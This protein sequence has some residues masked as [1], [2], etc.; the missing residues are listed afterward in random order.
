[1]AYECVV[2]T[3]IDAPAEKVW[4]WMSDARNLLAVNM[5]HEAVLWDEPI[6]EAG[7]RVPVP[8]QFGL[9]HQRRVAHL[10]RYQKYLIGFGET[11]S[12]DE[13]GTDA[14]PHYQEFEILPMDDGTCAIA[15]RLR[16]LYQFPG[17]KRYGEWI[18]HRWTPYILEDDN[19]TIAVAVGA[20]KPEEKPRLK[21]VLR[22]WP[23]FV[24][25]GRILSKRSRRKIVAAQRGQDAKAEVAPQPSGTIV[26]AVPNGSQAAEGDGE[27]VSA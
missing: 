24:L 15:N 14:F 20:M 17:A 12:K 13:P 10:R 26:A 9:V 2:L 5:F 8:H 27:S 22:L 7:A 11:K 21:G 1:M 4:E 18:F 16:G 6:R 25:G 19:A 3:H 23:L